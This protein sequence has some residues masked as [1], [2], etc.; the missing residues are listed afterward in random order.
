MKPW[1]C[2]RYIRA[3]SCSLQTLMRVAVVCGNPKPKSRTLEA[4]VF[5]AHR[6]TGAEPDVVLDLINLGEHLLGWGDDVS[7][8][9]VADVQACQVAVFASPTYKG[10]YTGL[11]KAV[12]RPGPD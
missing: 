7:A 11:L 8:K 2:R 1:L 3:T 10:A 12:P 6:L 9:A 5:V 4:A